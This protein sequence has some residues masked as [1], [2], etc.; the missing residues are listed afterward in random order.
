MPR[1]PPVSG[2]ENVDNLIIIRR[3]LSLWLGVHV[4]IKFC[5][6]CLLHS[7]VLSSTDVLEE[8]ISRD[9]SDKC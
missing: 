1:H 9:F 7:H 3:K 5:F 4:I 8:K 6:S 2:N